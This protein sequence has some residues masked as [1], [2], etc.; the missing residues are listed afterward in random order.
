[1]GP[2][3]ADVLVLARGRPALALEV[4]V[5]HAVDAAKIA[6]LAAAGVPVIEVDAREDWAREERDGTSIAPARTLGLPRC[7]TCLALARADAERGRGGEAAEVAELEAYRARGL[8]GQLSAT[9]AGLDAVARRF[10][11]PECGSRDV[12]RG[13]AIVRHAC[14]GAAS[15]PVAW[16]GFDGASVSLAWWRR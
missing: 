7:G 16:R 6:A 5:T 14:P 1:V 11:C 12:S 9:D 15:R 10:R 3:R 4:K 13:E 2:L 8:F